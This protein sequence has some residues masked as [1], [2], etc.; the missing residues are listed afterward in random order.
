MSLPAVV[1][2]WHRAGRS[3]GLMLGDLTFQCSI[4]GSQSTSA[5]KVTR[6]ASATKS[7]MMKGVTAPAARYDCRGL[8]W[9]LGDGALM[10]KNMA[11]QSNM[12]AMVVDDQGS[13]VKVTE[14]VLRALGFS[15]VVGTVTAE[16]A[17]RQ[18]ESKRYN[19]VISDWHMQPTSGPDLLKSI[20]RLSERNR[21]R[22]YF[23]TA[24]AP[25]GCVATARQLGAE[26]LII[27][28]SRP[29]ELMEKLSHAF[30]TSWRSA[31]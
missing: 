2:V 6:I 11:I 8:A 16:D 4:D 1:S 12:T 24:D 18:L 28:P 7:A 15:C 13:S 31:A 17:I 30:K 19:V 21:P 5:G 29:A 10:E 26:G 20:Q 14:A 22:F 3:S 23:L 9:M 27:K 25:W